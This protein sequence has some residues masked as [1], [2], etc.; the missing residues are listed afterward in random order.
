M[1]RAALIALLV[2]LGCQIPRPI[3]AFMLVVIAIGLGF[4]K[5]TLD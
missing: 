2:L 1:R 3:L 5:R 4:H